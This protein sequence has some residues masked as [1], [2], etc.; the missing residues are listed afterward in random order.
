MS[1]LVQLTPGAEFAG[2]FRIVRPLSEG[3][4][5]AVYVVEQV[6]TGKQ[7]ALKVMHPSLVGDESL[8]Q[9]FVQEARIGAKIDSDHV[10][11]VVAAGID[12]ATSTPWLA[13]ELLQGETLAE[14]VDT[15]GPRHIAEVREVLGQLCHALAA[16]HKVGIVHRDL[17]PENIFLG[18][19]RREGVPFVVKVLDFGIA[20]LVAEAETKQTAAMGSPLWMSPEQAD[21]G[22]LIS[23]RTDVW[24]LGLIVFWMLTGKEYW[25][26]AHVENPNPVQL[27][28]EMKFNPLVTASER[29]K[30]YGQLEKL[31]PRFDL[32][33]GKCVTRELADRYADAREARRG[34][35][36]L[37]GPSPAR[38]LKPAAHPADA[39]VPAKISAPR[40]EAIDVPDLDFTAR[41]STLP[42]PPVVHRPAPVASIDLAV[43]PRS[44]TSSGRHRAV[45]DVPAPKI[46]HKP[47]PIAPKPEPAPISS[48]P[49]S[50]SQPIGAVTSTPASLPPHASTR[51]SQPSEPP[52]TAWWK[53]ALIGVVGIAVI[54]G[55]LKLVLAAAERSANKDDTQKTAGSNSPPGVIPESALQCPAGMSALAGGSFD[56][57]N[58]KVVVESFCM[59][60][61]EVTVKAYATCVHDGKCT[62]SHAE[63][64]WSAPNAE[65]I[66]LYDKS[67]NGEKVDKTNHPVNC[68]DAAQADAFC[69]AYGK[70]LPNEAQWEWAARGKT[71]RWPYPWGKEPPDN[72]LCW[73]QFT[74]RGG[75]CNV[76]EYP[77]GDDPWGVQ[78]LDGNVREWLRFEPGAK[79]R[80]YCGS[81]WTDT[82]DTFHALGACAFTKPDATSGF[83]GFRCVK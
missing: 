9:R 21:L 24:A 60:K 63:G 52:P 17:K 77:R 26:G 11:E 23:P 40:M 47:E 5:G 6:S 38:S 75:T 70:Q 20:K 80:E 67:C 72:H 78:D 69:A 14:R 39:I 1:S 30:E 16:A 44:S 31:P 48:P 55:G 76:G 66:A 2:E 54:W 53:W 65:Q 25:K 56:G 64:T 81:D 35:E 13:M 27:V 73:S 29:A 4:M 7:R 41:P 61:T 82:R 37:N 50:H 71:E 36:E 19:A 10:V 3:G 79:E 46:E 28:T 8:R 43:E 32:W 45:V 62:A 49:L 57:G 33:F 68:V 59:D 83:L 51:V 42:K 58:G 22:G 12:P 18:I 15:M 74:H 34:F